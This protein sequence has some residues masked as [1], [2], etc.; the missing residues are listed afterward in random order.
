MA[1]VLGLDLAQVERA[2]AQAADGQVV[3]PANVN[4]PGQI[5]IAGHAAAV[6]RA[7]TLC[8]AA[9]AKRAVLLPVSAPFHCALMRPAQD[10]L[11]AHLA[12]VAFAEPKTPLVNNVD[13]RPVRSAVECR[14]GLVRQVTAAVLWQQSV[15]LLVGQGVDTFVEIGPGGVLSGLV[16]RIAKGVRTLNVEDP[17]SLAH[18]VA[19]LATDGVPRSQ[20][21]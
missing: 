15:E 13:A 7:S 8:R 20:E 5:V 21:S 17:A 1:A 11:A 18:T 4:S 12:G 2:C 14:E 6:E 10:R 9:G 3:S 16:K 19:A